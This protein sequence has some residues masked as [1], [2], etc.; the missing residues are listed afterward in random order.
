[1]QSG[2]L[3]PAAIGLGTWRHELIL[4]P[5]VKVF[6]YVPLAPATR[7][8][9]GRV[10]ADPL[11]EL[12]RGIGAMADRGV[13]V[14]GNYD[15][16]SFTFAK[17]TGRYRAIPGSSANPTMGEIGKV[18]AEEEAILTFVVPKDALGE[19]L[20]AIKDN[21]PYETP[22][23]EVFDLVRHEWDGLS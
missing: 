18:H 10:F 13:G 17:G 21:H 12:L 2:R 15:N 7:A 6:V 9:D 20:R 1:M 23:I 3:A 16:V 22:A 4:K 8:I 11:G 19:V 14:V 5:F